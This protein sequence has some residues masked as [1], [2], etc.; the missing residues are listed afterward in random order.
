[1]IQVNAARNG[2]QVTVLMTEVGKRGDHE[3]EVA[4]SFK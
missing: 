3:R 2:A 1:M 4:P